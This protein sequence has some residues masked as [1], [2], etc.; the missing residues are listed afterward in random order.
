MTFFFLLTVYF[1]I[2]AKETLVERNYRKSILLFVGAEVASIAAFFSK[3]HLFG[4]FPFYV[5]FV[6]IAMMS[7]KLSFR[8]SALSV[9][10]VLVASSVTIW[11]FNQFM[12]WKIFTQ[13]WFSI[14]TYGNSPGNDVVPDLIGVGVMV[15]K[16]IGSVISHFRFSDFIPFTDL[17]R[18]VFATESSLFMLYLLSF[19]F[20]EIRQNKVL[21]MMNIYQIFPAYIYLF[22]SMLFENQHGFHYLFSLYTLMC[23]QVAYLIYYGAKQ[24]KGKTVLSGLILILIIHYA[25]LTLGFKAHRDRAQMGETARIA[26]LYLLQLK[27]GEKPDAVTCK[28]IPNMGIMT[29]NY[30][31]NGE[32]SLIELELGKLIND[33]Q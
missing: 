27:P 11:F 32:P 6:L 25:S 26:Y 33:Q 5:F 2:L 4:P 19:G 7:K 12:D 20:R 9:F 30:Y 31:N 13:D 24:I 8:Q 14:A 28:A 3:I 10:M 18:I 29:Y 21:M 16:R 23:I 1:L 15:I 17:S 22:R